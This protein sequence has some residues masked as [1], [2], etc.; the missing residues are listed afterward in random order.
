MIW[1]KITKH[2]VIWT[3][4][5]LVCYDILAY[6]QFNDSTISVFIWA[7]SQKYPPIPFLFGVLMG[8][9]FFPAKPIKL[10]DIQ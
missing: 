9:F 6:L 7:W 5:I 2:L 4:V 8:H 1:R 3:T 10:K